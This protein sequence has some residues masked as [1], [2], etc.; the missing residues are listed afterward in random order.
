MSKPNKEQ[1]MEQLGTVQDPDLHKSLVALNMIK[2]VVISEGKVHVHV[3][4]TTPACPLKDKISADIQSAVGRLDGVEEVTV[5]FSATVR[6]SSSKGSVLPGVKN[7]VAVGA[8]KGGVGKST[9]AVMIA[10]GLARSGAAVGLLDADIYGPS[11]PTMMG[12]KGA[13]PLTANERILP[14]ESAGVKIISMGFM[15]EPDQAVVWR[16]PMVHSAVSQFLQQVEWGELDYLIV[17]LPPGTGDVPLS[18]AQTIPMTGSVIVCT[19]QDVALADARRAV[20]MYQQ[21]N[22]KCLGIIENMSYYCCPKCGHRDEIFDH[23]GAE[24]AAASLDVPYLGAIPL[25]ARLREFGDDG[26]PEA[27]FGDAGAEIQ[28]A[29]EEVVGNVASQISIANM[30]PAS[31]PTLSVE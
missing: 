10:V 17:D 12:K 1:V 2:D 28:Q 19:P 16:G 23:G 15:L 3:E 30:E 7:V 11:I 22:V 5:E 18:L 20:R 27:A 6:G 24:K 31:Q 21:L 13:K 26:K 8:G 25:N 9:T 4:L 29:I 14:I